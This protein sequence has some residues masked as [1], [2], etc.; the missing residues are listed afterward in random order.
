MY[1][2]TLFLLPRSVLSLNP[3]FGGVGA[4]MVEK[5]QVQGER[6]RL[7]GECWAKYLYYPFYGQL[8]FSSILN[9]STNSLCWFFI[10]LN[11]I[12]E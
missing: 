11:G 6:P 4:Q 2:V 5:S 1:R 10:E 3:S 7:G 8:L 12:R 9:P